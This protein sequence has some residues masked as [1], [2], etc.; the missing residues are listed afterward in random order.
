[1]SGDHSTTD[2]RPGRFCPPGYQ[3]APTDLARGEELTAETLYVVG[4][5]YGNLGA[6][7]AIESLASHERGPVQLVF[8]GDF[9]WFDVDDE[10]FRRV[11]ETVLDHVALRG[12][13]ETE[14]AAAAGTAGCGCG[15]PAW[16]DDATVDASN[17]IF[18]RL[19][20]TA[21]RHPELTAA[22]GDLPMY[23]RARVGDLRV[24]I[25]HGDAESLAGWDFA[26]ERVNDPL[27]QQRYRTW[28][29]QAQAD[30][31]AS[32]HTCLPV[33]LC[34]DDGDTH[35]VLINNGAAGMPNFRGDLRG[36]VTRISVDPSP[37]PTQFGA[38]IGGIHID[39]VPVA[40]DVAAWMRDFRHNW[41][42]G[43]PAHDSY[44]KRLTQGPDYRIAQAVRHGIDQREKCWY[45][46]ISDRV[47]HE[48]A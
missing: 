21:S 7:D 40:Y 23:R 11:S 44:Y 16:V 10:S 39:A 43:S 34:L 25:V 32:S 22:L 8:N 6:L 2:E 13:V 42:A 27:Q 46:H 24:A 48:T 26:Q 38:R 14:L 37:L 19:A 41:P 36:L 4:G 3:Y 33:A 45:S 30:L 20:E 15:Y 28:F 29:S 47:R 17:A 5:L 1:M 35:R 18:A 31:F 9:H 12:N